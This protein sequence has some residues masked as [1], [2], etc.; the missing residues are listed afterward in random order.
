M[1]VNSIAVIGGGPCGAAAA[2][3]FMAEKCFNRIKVFERRAG[4][5]GLWNY[6][7][8]TDTFPVPNETPYRIKPIVKDSIRWPSAAYDLLDTNVPTDLMTYSGHPFPETLPIFPHRSDVLKYMQEYAKEAEAITQFNTVVVLVT[9][10][11][12]QWQVVSRPVTAETA[13]GEISLGED[14]VESFDA[15]VVAVGN[16]EVPFIP[17]RPGMV[18]WNERYAGNISHVKAYKSPQ[19]YKDVQGAILVVGNSASAGDICYQL[20]E[21]LGRTIYKSRRSENL[22]PASPSDKI[23]DKPDI[24]HFDAANKRVYFVDS[25]FLENVDK[26][27][28]ATGYLKSYPFLQSLNHTK[29][30]LLTDGHKVHGVYRHVLA[31]NFP[32]LAVVGIPKF[33]LPTRVSESQA[34]WLAKVWLGEIA[35]PSKDKMEEWEKTRLALKGNGKNFH[36]MNFP[37]DVEYCNL[38]NNEILHAIEKLHRGLEPF[39]WD[40]SQVRIRASVKAIKEA[41]VRYR[42]KTGKLAANYA[43]LS[44]INPNVLVDD[45][46][47]E[48]KGFGLAR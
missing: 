21:G 29:T 17:S 34:C 22:Q 8:E 28:F 14:T 43:E 7:L 41:F 46:V 30:P 26:V 36:D 40:R 42:D 38:L 44:K 16:Y 33:V 24:D 45:N 3:A 1:S 48:E 11:S 35:L 12:D 10:I 25:T 6:E 13:G 39:V 32:N 23:E 4:F 2:K 31:Y 19:Q 37:E 5:G 20:A 47:L 9:R 27:I 18:E 15:V